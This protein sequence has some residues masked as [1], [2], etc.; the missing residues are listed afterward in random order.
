[1]KDTLAK[2]KL[3][4]PNIASIGMATLFPII[5]LTNHPPDF[6]DKLNPFGIAR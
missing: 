1:M 5:Q 6:G 2:F 4:C 3:I